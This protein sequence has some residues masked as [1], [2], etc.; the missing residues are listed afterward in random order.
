MSEAVKISVII[1]CYNCEQW[2]DETLESLENQTFK[3]FET[4]CV[5]DGSVDGTRDKLR[6]WQAKGTLNLKIVDKPN[7]GV[8]RARNAGIQNA[9]GEFV[10]FLDSDDCYN[11]SFIEELYSATI[12]NASDTAYCFYR[13]TY[14]DVME[15]KAPN[16]AKR[17]L[18]SQTE[19]MHNLM[20]R[21][22]ELGFA[23]Y[24]YR[25]DILIKEN[26]FFDVNTKNFEDRE[27]NWKYLCHCRSVVMIDAPLYYYRVVSGSATRKVSGEWRTD[28]RDAAQRVEKYL[29]EQNCEFYEELKSFLVSRIAWGDA[30][31]MVWAR[32]KAGLKRM[33]REYDMKTH[34]KQ[35]SRKDPDWKVRLTARLYL[36]H[37]ALFYFA[38][39]LK[40]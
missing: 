23:C 33:A 28:R 20:Y 16:S 38:V 4:I 6:A 14:A 18:Q 29:K 39:G 36:I 30:K 37:P 32:N 26:I 11:N 22:A 15:R 12:E 34:M 3:N 24:L 8:S 40:K 21:M 1:P 2:V 13:R 5:N 7:G 10:L 27:F 9:V 19:A 31:R 25:K 17:V 35:V